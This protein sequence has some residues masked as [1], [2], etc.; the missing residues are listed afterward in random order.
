[1]TIIRNTTTKLI[2]R[3][4]QLQT[5]LNTRPLVTAKM[6]TLS[7]STTQNMPCGHKIP[8]LGFGVYQTPANEASDA[9][10]RALDAGYRHVD[11]AVMYRN[12]KPCGEAIRKSGIPRE[13]IFFT[14]KIYGRDLN[15]ESATKQIQGTVDAAGL[16]YVDC[17]LIHAPYGHKGGEGRK[18][19]WKAL[20]EAQE[21]GLTK[22]IGVSN[23][24]THHLLELEQH[25]KQ[26][27]E[28]RGNGGKI[29]IGQWE[30]HPWLPRD[31][32]VK[33]CRARGTVVEAYSPLVRGEKGDDETLNGIAKKHGKSWAQV[34]VRWS[35]QK[36]YVPLPKSVTPKRI[37]E[38]KE[39]YDFELDE[40]DM[41]KLDMPYEYYVCAWDPTVNDPELREQFSKELEAQGL[42][43]GPRC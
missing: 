15:Y 24:G 17:I 23:Y 34:L 31:D 21:K 12:E 27:E 30:I 16:G 42:L 9:V 5:H 25:I 10:S 40:E 2:S 8:Q 37:I 19:A 13:Q 3:A 6:P 7:I 36:G 38:N 26:L 35:L 28:E 14:S 41:K 33:F 29:D 4:S 20:V 32:I 43:I 22:S 39:V 1:M 11:S 18:G